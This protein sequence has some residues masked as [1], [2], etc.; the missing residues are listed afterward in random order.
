M[1]DVPDSFLR[2]RRLAAFY[3]L[4]LLVVCGVMAAS[5]SLKAFG[6]LSDLWAFL[7]ANRLYPNLVTIGRF[8]LR[9][10]LAWLIFL[11]AAAPTLSA[12]VVSLGAGGLPGLSALLSRLSPFGPDVS[13]REAARAWGL[14][15]GVSAVLTGAFLWSAL[16]LGT[17]E[18]KAFILDSLGGTPLAILGTLLV[19]AFID[20]GGTLEELGWRGFALPALLDRGHT[21]WGATALLATL[22]WAWHLPR[23]LFGLVSGT[24]VGRF[25]FVQAQFLLLCLALS[26][27]ITYFWQRTGGSA[28]TGLF[29]HGVTNL[30]SKA[31]SGPLN[32]WLGTDSRT[33]LAF[34]AA[35]VVLLAAGRSLGQPARFRPEEARP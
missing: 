11:F 4:A 20:E 24:P 16:A 26:I 32:G 23:E 33:L 19:G 22:W 25:L 28:L 13:R 9:E 12:I 35:L 21:P 7:Q 30:W 17:A 2:R 6:L 29:V 27:V 8:A 31:L 14:L 15:L 10:P 1:P 34:A 3:G 18:Q 5:F